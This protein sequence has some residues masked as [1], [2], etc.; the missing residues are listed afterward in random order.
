MLFGDLKIFFVPLTHQIPPS[1]NTF[2][3][4]APAPTHASQQK[5][6]TGHSFMYLVFQGQ[7]ENLT[8]K[9]HWLVKPTLLL[10]G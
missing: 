1:P 4:S 3:Q 6:E 5:L 10:L 7:K 8:V 9:Y 2:P